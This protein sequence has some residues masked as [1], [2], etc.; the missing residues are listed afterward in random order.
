M[1]QSYTNVDYG[2]FKIHLGK[3]K[4]FAN[5]IITKA[6]EKLEIHFK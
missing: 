2:V 6:T 1:I 4:M 3:K 5:L